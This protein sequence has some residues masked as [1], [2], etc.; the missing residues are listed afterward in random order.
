MKFCIMMRRCKPKPGTKYISAGTRILPVGKTNIPV[1]K[2]MMMDP[3]PQYMQQRQ[4]A[5][6]PTMK[7]EYILQKKPWSIQF[8]YMYICMYVYVCVYIYI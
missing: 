2:N 4:I 6:M 7:N 5:D 1:I 3:K 8:I